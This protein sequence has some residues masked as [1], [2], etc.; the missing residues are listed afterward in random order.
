MAIYK[1][2]NSKYYWYKFMFDGVLI[3][4]SSKCTNKADARVVES[5]HLMQLK[6]GKLGI[7][8]ERKIKKEVPTFE[9]SAKDFLKWSELNHKNKPRSY[10]RVTFS[11]APLIEK[12]GK[13]K[14]DTIKAD[15]IEKYQIW[16]SKQISKKTKLEITADTINM[17]LIVLK[18]IFRRLFA[19]GHI[20]KNP[21][22]E[23]KLLPKNKRKFYVLTEDDER[24]YLMACTQP[25]QDVAVLILETGCRPDEIYNLKRQS[26]FIEQGYLRVEDGKTESANRKIPLSDRAAAV[27]KHRLSKFKGDY[28]FPKKET[29]FNSPTYELNWYHR[30]A[31]SQTG[32]K[33]RI[34]DLRH[35][36][37]SRLLESGKVDLLTLAALL[38][39]SSLGQVM[40][41]AHP[42]DK[43]KSDAIKTNQRKAV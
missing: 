31:L 33:F 30:A 21:T 10:R 23:T 17:E 12:F 40:R 22:A 2:A 16:R 8:S 9:Q 43:S 18:T 35:T 38:G 1:R 19:A 25:L 4:Q 29:D 24:R 7:E 6:L 14:V 13:R 20:K 28:L 36:F 15:E 41:Y 11:T 34:Y 27:L 42:S 39:H 3:Q 26:V 32:Q 37:A 5:G